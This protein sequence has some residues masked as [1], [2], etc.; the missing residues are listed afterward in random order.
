MA[1]QTGSSA[2][3]EN[4]MVQLSAFLTA[5]GW[6][7]D[8]FT[9]GDGGVIG[10]SKNGVFVCFKWAETTDGG[11]LAVYQNTSNDNST[12]LWLATG[13]SGSGT[14]SNTLT[15]LDAARSVNQ[16]AGPHS[17]YWFFENDSNPAYCHVVVEVD[18]GRFRHFGFGEIEKIGV[19]TGGEYC[20]GHWW[21]Q[22]SS[23]IDNPAAG[24]HDFGM[25]GYSLQST[26]F[27]GTMRVDG[28]AGEPSAATVWA[29]MGSGN[30]GAAGNDRAGNPRY[31]ASGGWRVSR[32][33]QHLHAF[34]LSLL[35]AF[36]PMATVPVELLNF[37]GAPD[38]I[39]R[40]G[41][42]AD[43]RMMNIANLDPGQIINIAGDN[44]YFFPW[45]RKQFLQNNTEESWNGGI[46]Y[47]RVDA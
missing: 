9:T 6:T 34:E 46:A 24:Q 13:D 14:A 35:N 45:V 10:F 5:N 37:A 27:R 41:Y 25:E 43:I 1:F 28:Y 23:T 26:L 32:E 18:A 19:W 11:T 20:Y 21:N 15:N 44:W 42:Q 47:K 31:Q 16:F 3:I 36:K 22:G 40:V 8:F 38:Q 2:S 4:L 7:Q 12:S 33:F 39:R 17:G 30:T 29:L